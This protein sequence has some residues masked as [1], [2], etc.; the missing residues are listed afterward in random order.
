MTSP[1]VRT[2]FPVDLSTDPGE[3]DRQLEHLLLFLPSGLVT[4][5]EPFGFS[6]RRE[7]D[8]FAVIAIGTSLGMGILLAEFSSQVRYFSY[9]GVSLS[10]FFFLAAVALSWRVLRNRLHRLEFAADGATL[11]RR[12]MLGSRQV[13]AERFEAEQIIEV[14]VLVPEGEEPRVVLGGPRHATLGEIFRPRALDPERLAPWMAEMIA[15]VAR[16]ASLTTTPDA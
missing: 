9:V 10:V 12:E 3:L 8:A 15:L 11:V 14:L 16:R 1:P 5:L 4:R 7:P 2:R 6:F 13:R